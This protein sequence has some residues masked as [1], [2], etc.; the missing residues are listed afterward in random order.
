MSESLS[1]LTGI[2]RARIEDFNWA[3]A[4][5]SWA[6]GELRRLEN[7]AAA[8]R[9]DCRLRDAAADTADAISEQLENW[10]PSHRAN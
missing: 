7:L 3:V 1:S 5:F 4:T 2:Q 6:V 9:S 8:R 10:D